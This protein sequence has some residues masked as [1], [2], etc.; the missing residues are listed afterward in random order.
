[1]TVYPQHGFNLVNQKQLKLSN[2]GLVNIKKHRGLEGEIKNCSILIKNGK[3]YACFSCEVEPKPLPKTKKKIGIDMGL[4][5]FLAT[6][7]EELK[8]A[9]K[10][11]RKAEKQL[12]KA[13]RKVSRRT[14]GSKRRKKAVRILP[15]NMK[16][17]A[18][19]EKTWLTS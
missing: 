2:I 3:Y 17:L 14:K 13:Q 15:L 16:K 18:I 10:T 19:K 4:T 8:E 7:D 11:Y 9:P 6:S 5:S 12:A 1:M